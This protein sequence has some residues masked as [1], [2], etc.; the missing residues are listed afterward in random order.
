MKRKYFIK[1]NDWGDILVFNGNYIS[2]IE[3]L[4][5]VIDYA[6]QLLVGGYRGLRVDGWIDDYGNNRFDVRCDPNLPEGQ[7]ILEMYLGYEKD[8]T[9]HLYEEGFTVVEN[10]YKEKTE[11]YICL[12]H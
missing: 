3:N 4:H 7:L 1:C 2:E 5:S 9:L 11:S 12:F 10:K 8:E 6:I